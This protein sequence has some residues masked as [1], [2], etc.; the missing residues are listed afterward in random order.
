MGGYLLSRLGDSTIGASG[1]NF[2]VRNGKRWGTGAVA[3]L[4][5]G[6]MPVSGT[7]HTKRAEENT[8]RRLAGRTARTQ[9]NTPPQG[10]RSLGQLVVLGFGVAAFTPAPYPRHRL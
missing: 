1:L 9:G 8:S 4:G 7:M 3:T 5:M 10:V 6:D 2:S